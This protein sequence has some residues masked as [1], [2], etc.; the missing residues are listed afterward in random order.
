MTDADKIALLRD[1]LHNMTSWT[2]GL[3]THEGVNLDAQTEQWIER[4]LNTASKCLQSCRIDDVE[5]SQ[6][7]QTEF[8]Q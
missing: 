3:L 2:R 6:P 8:V 4:D 1:S 5:V 7:L